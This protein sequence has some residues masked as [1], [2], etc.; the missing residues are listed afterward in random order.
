MEITL[1]EVAA[2]VGG[3]IVGD[4][5]V[6]VSGVA[7]IREAQSGQ[8]TFLSNPKYERYLSTTS[9]SAIIVSRGYAGREELNGKSLVVSENPYSAFAIV[10]EM[11]GG[12]SDTV[13]EGVHPSAVIAESATIGR[14]VSIGPH[15]VVAGG[16][17]IGD[18]VVLYPGVY[19][20]AG[21]RIGPDT[22]IRPNVTLKAESR[23]GE[24]VIVHSG[25]VIGSDGFG[26]ATV[27]GVHH[28]IPQIGT[29]VIEDDVEIGANTCV[30]R[31]RFD[32]TII[33]HG[34]K[35]DNLCQIAHNV[36]IGENSFIVAQTAIAGSAR[37]GAN[38]IL[39]GQTGINGHIE[40][41][42]GVR[43]ASRSGITKDVPPGTAVGGFP[44]QPHRRELELQA[45]L[46]RLP[47]IAAHLKELTDK[48]AE[49]EE[50][51]GGGRKG[52][53]S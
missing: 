49:L 1:E 38:V 34:T 50:R 37:I 17:T 22:I 31:A 29:V 12:A 8:L 14:G 52:K 36:V 44:A 35:I 42:D 51:L 2:R 10:V 25:S 21:V 39:A 40:V 30:D 11:F 4:G 18:R 3:T 5:S 45:H 9:A 16:A 20:G 32:R 28:K 46:R 41:G 13:E 19:V 23:I 47:E 15:V 43:A 7:G 33:K 24:R 48:I 6:V 53:K 27:E 26:F